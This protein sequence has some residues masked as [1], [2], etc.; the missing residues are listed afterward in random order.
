MPVFRGLC[1][2]TV[3]WCAPLTLVVN[4]MWE[5]SCRTRVVEHPQRFHETSAVDITWNSHTAIS[6]SR[7]KC[8][9]INLGI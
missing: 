1:A 3:M 2:G 6:S 4:R 8:N 7:T 9:R 5:P